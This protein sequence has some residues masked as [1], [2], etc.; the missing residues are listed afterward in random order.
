MQGYVAPPPRQKKPIGFLGFLGIVFAML[1]CGVGMCAVALRQTPAEKAAYEQKTRELGAKLEAEKK[2]ADE[3]RAA[4]RKACRMKPDAAINIEPSHIV[5]LCQDAVNAH[6][7]TGRAEFPYGEHERI[8]KETAGCGRRLASEY[9]AKNAFGV[10]SRNRYVCD[11]DPKT[12]SV[13]VQN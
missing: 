10:E 2:A 11:F 3:E 5:G 4:T 7:R 13:K 8:L 1:L 9:T 12:D 6:L